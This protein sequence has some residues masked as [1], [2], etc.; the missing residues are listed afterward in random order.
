MFIRDTEIEEGCEAI[1]SLV[2]HHKDNN[3][4]L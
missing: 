3:S 4:E 1:F 2:S